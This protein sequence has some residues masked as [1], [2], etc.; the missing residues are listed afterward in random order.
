MAKVK[1]KDTDGTWKLAGADDATLIEAKEYADIIFGQHSTN[2]SN[3]HNVTLTQL[4]VNATTAELDVLNGATITTEELNYMDGV[5]SNIQAQL[6]TLSNDKVSKDYV[7][8]LMVID[9]TMEV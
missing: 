4:G 9:T 1:Y 5:K 3:P 8:S 7:D 2:T 6:D